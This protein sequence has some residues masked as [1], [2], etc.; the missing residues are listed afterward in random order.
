MN[1]G[2]ADG[3]PLRVVVVEDDASIRH[4]VRLAF[5]DLAVDLVLCE[6]VEAAWRAMAEKP[7]GLVITDLMLPP[8]PSGLVLVER[9]AAAR[10][11]CPTGCVAVFSAGISPVQREQ[12]QALGVWRVLHKPV[13]MSELWDCVAQAR[14]RPAV[15]APAAPAPEDGTTTP[16]QRSIA[17]HFGGDAVLRDEFFDGCR[18]QFRHDIDTG[19]QACARSDTGALR[20][21]LHSLKTVL[22][23]LGYEDLGTLARSAEAHAAA[24]EAAPAAALWRTLRVELS[25]LAERGEMAAAAPMR[26]VV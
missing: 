1:E 8:G 11:L 5:E 17:L 6:D 24:G 3:P 15:A 10:H 2:E 26:R 7:A 19:D 12:L 23:T 25:A 20:V 22:G 13:P 18:V 9:L 16:R 4:F 21:M 14:Q